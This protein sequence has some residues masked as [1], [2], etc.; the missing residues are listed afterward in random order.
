MDFL[1][2]GNKFF[3]LSFV[4]GGGA[5]GTCMF[6]YWKETMSGEFIR[7]M[8]EQGRRGGTVVKKERMYLSG[9]GRFQS[10]RG[11]IAYVMAMEKWL[12][13]VVSVLYFKTTP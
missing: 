13:N 6:E 9:P 3:F 2:F 5:P 11:G 1:Q 7:V 8:A 12:S 10:A 4:G